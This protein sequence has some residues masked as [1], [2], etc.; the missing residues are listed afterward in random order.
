MW[1]AADSWGLLEP[2][3]AITFLLRYRA[4]CSRKVPG[5]RSTT[6]NKG[7]MRHSLR[8]TGGLQWSQ[9][10]QRVKPLHHEQDASSRKHE[11]SS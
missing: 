8:R 9:R 6:D 1:G 2:S 5:N 10:V 3:R 11:A 4:V 7:E